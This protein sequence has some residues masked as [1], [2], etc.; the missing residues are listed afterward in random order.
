MPS[1][2]L[3]GVNPKAGI[4]DLHQIAEKKMAVKM[5]VRGGEDVPI[6]KAVLEY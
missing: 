2:F 3:V 4:T 1:Y 6:N 5:L